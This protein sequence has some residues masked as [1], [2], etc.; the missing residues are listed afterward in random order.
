MFDSMSLQEA[1]SDLYD[2]GLKSDKLKLLYNANKQVK[3]KVKTPSGLTQET[4]IREVVMQGDTWAITMDSVQCDAFG[5][6]L[7]EENVSYLYTSI[8]EEFQSEFL[9]K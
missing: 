2:I 9:V 6:E 7:L 4:D 3:I 1:C 5:K 8:K